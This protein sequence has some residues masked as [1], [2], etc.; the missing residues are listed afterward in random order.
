MDVRG[1]LV[2]GDI[3][4]ATVEV[5][6]RASTEEVTDMILQIMP[7]AEEHGVGRLE[8]IEFTLAWFGIATDTQVEIDTSFGGPDRA[9]ARRLARTLL[10]GSAP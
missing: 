4:Y 6:H 9:E 10:A 3:T 2:N 7:L 1:D 8:S 5:S